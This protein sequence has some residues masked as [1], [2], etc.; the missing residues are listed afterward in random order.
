[1]TDNLFRK[2]ERKFLAARLDD[3]D[4]LK[5]A[6]K[7]VDIVDGDLYSPRDQLVDELV[8]ALLKQFPER[9]IETNPNS[10]LAW[11]QKERDRLHTVSVD[12]RH[13]VA[14]DRAL[15][16]VRRFMYN[17]SARRTSPLDNQTP[18]RPKV[19]S[20]LTLFKQRY[21]REIK[22]RRDLLACGKE[23]PALLRAY[24]IAVQQELADLRAT[25]PDEYAELE[26]AA[27]ALREEGK[28][29]FEEQ[30]AEVQQA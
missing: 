8:E 28:R 27:E 18:L 16:R 14:D 19:V 30:T 21:A 13:D 25:S 12:W 10:D 6:G 20:V 5:G 4:S 11:Q 17:A 3:W 23:G 9:N 22:A 29:P 7:Q 26:G 15:Q 24:N 2:Q 1:M